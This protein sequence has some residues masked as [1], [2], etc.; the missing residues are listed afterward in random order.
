MKI[1][2]DGNDYERQNVANNTKDKDDFIKSSNIRMK[3][4]GQIVLHT[5][6]SLYHRPWAA[7]MSELLTDEDVKLVKNGLLPIK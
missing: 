4:M 6:S 7:I 5:H 1:T 2:N 3:I